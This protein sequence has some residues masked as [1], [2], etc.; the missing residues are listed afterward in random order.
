MLNS[1]LGPIVAPIVESA[2]NAVNADSLL[3][4]GLAGIVIFA[5]FGTTFLFPRKY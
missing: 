1:L 5:M 3:V 4:A 2:F